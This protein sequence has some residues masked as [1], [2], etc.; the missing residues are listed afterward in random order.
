MKRS[1]ILLILLSALCLPLAAQTGHEA[2]TVVL[3]QNRPPVK[4][5]K[6][7]RQILS[8][9]FRRQDDKQARQENEVL[10]YELDSLQMLVD[11]L[12]NRVF[13]DEQ[14]ISVL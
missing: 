4:E 13:F 3:E 6:P 9:L 5:R 7:F 1:Y 8:E 2:E 12:R 11:S 14:E 10:R